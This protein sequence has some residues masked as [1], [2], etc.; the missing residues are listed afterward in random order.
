MRWADASQRFA[1]SI[2]RSVA[3]LTAWPFPQMGPIVMRT[4]ARG[5]FVAATIAA[6]GVAPV[7]AQRK[8]ADVSVVD[9]FRRA[10]LSSPV[11]SPDGRRLA[12]L[13]SGPGGR[14]ALAVADVD[15]P[16]RRTGVA[17]F[18][19][20]DIR[21]IAW[22]NNGRILM[23]LYDPQSPL[24]EQHG[25]G[26]YAVDV[27][28][29][30]FVFLVARRSGESSGGHLAVRPLRG[31]H[32]YFG[33][34]PPGDSDDVLMQRWHL[35]D[36]EGAAGGSDLVRVN[37]RTRA[38]TE[39]VKDAPKNASDWVLDRDGVPRAALAFDGKQALTVWARS[40]SSSRW[41][42]IDSY[43]IY[44]TKPGAI[45]PVG[46]KDDGTMVVASVRDNHERTMALY[47]YDL[48]GRKR[49]DEPFLAVKGFDLEGGLLFEGATRRLVGV[50][51]ATD[52][53][54]VAWLDDDMK[55]LQERV[56]ALLPGNNNV[57]LCST[58]CVAHDRLLLQSYSDRQP[59]VYFLVD[60]TRTGQQ[61]LTLIGTGRPWI[62]AA[63][64]ASQDMVRI[65]ARDGMEIPIYIT[66]PQGK[67][68]FPLV[69][70]VHGGPFVRGHEWGWRPES[71][72]LASR[73]YLV[74]EPEFRGSTGYGQLLHRA[75]WKQWGL[76]MQDDL[77][78]AA[79]WAVAGGL[80]DPKRMVIAGASYGGYAAMMGLVKEPDL[81]RAG[82]NW[83]GVTD[84]ELLTSVSWSDMSGSPWAK[85]GMPEMVGDPSKDRDQLD[86]TS[87]L[88]RASEITKPVLMAYGSKDVRVP[89]PH[90][91]K[92]RD[93]LLSAGKVPVE[94]IVYENEGHGF[95]LERNNVDFW[96][97]V[98]RFLANNTR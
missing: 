47:D 65:S 91:A 33:N 55:R 74:I 90:G 63:Q 31:N 94:W 73:G 37:T 36:H 43:D 9:F 72:F 87:P 23:S 41:N 42:S 71:Q 48:V 8:P 27:D 59:P 67:G 5:L 98:E 79:R 49:A 6:F 16:N 17:R 11:L 10:T 18:D 56:D 62:D 19:D 58:H 13:V 34:L 97:R 40:S 38:V 83:V 95:M 15:A 45:V 66:K 44:R 7:W 69:M 30:D 88:K 21:D 28:G 39:L 53:Q 46:F 82:I 35:L 24:G 75:G 22:V 89:L 86:R 54:G 26:A 29:G 3:T 68:P 93:A 2:G 70:L 50:R 76:K 85:Y 80:A 52:A 81:Y 84:I 60:K 20:A 51:Y 64:M 25:G 14:N 1:P 57:F 4:L 77:T 92:M 96:I 78:D 61:S 32:S 12:M